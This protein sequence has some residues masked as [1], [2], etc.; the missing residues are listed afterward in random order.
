MKMASH[1]T[2]RYVEGLQTY[3]TSFCKQMILFVMYSCIVVLKTQYTLENLN[4]LPYLNVGVVEWGRRHS[5][6]ISSGIAHDI[7]CLKF[8]MDIL[9]IPIK[10]QAQLGA[11]IFNCTRCNDTHRLV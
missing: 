10:L 2:S 5:H 4:K 3:N 7:F 6:D 9:E 1:L 8:V 11:P